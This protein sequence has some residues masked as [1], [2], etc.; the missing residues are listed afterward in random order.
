M[1]LHWKN[2]P[3]DINVVFE[4]IQW[5]F[6]GNLAFIFIISLLSVL[7]NFLSIYLDWVWLLYMQSLL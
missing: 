4:V 5:F 7:D 3:K 1:V 2:Y 6:V